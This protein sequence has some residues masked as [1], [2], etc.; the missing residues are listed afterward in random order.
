ME[1]ADK[2]VEGK[3]LD[4]DEYG[5]LIVETEEGK[6]RVVAGDVTILSKM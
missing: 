6:K 4:I 5:A 2:I 1:C 3:A